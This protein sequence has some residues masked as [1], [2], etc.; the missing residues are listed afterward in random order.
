MRALSCSCCGSLCY[1]V[2]M[3]AL[4]CSCCVPSSLCIC[5]YCT[6]ESSELLL[7]CLP[8]LYCTY[9]SSKLLLLRLFLLYC[10]VYMCMLYL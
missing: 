6:Y 9:E 2:P 10:I 8:L 1:T 3:R 7:L 5:V 4:S